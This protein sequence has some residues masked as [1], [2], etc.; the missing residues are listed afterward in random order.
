MTTIGF[1]ASSLDDIGTA[2]AQAQGREMKPENHPEYGYYYRSDH[3]EFAK[4]GVPAYYPRSGTHFIGK[5]AEFG[6]QLVQDYLANRYHKVTDEVQPNWTF[7]GAAQDT[8][9]LMK[10]GHRVAD[11]ESWPQWREGN[12][13][14]ARRDAMM[15]AAD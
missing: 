6:E 4:V 3:F 12:E 14:K 5:P 10:V 15:K 1:G 13:F 7:E 11:A 9:F 8:E 2:V